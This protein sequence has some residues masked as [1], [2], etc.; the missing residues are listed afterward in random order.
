MMQ[1]YVITQTS[2]WQVCSVPRGWMR[3]IPVF[4]LFPHARRTMHPQMVRE[5]TGLVYPGP[6]PRSSR[7]RAGRPAQERCGAGTQELYAVSTAARRATRGQRTASTTMANR[8]AAAQMATALAGV[9]CSA[10]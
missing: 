5:H 10:R 8:L 1:H 3:G 6:G 4:G 7:W 2:N 9:V